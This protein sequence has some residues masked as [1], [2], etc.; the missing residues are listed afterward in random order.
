MREQLRRTVVALALALPAGSSAQEPVTLPA[1]AR[2]RLLTPPVVSPPNAPTSQCGMRVVLVD[3]SLDPAFVKP[4][5]EGPVRFEIRKLPVPC[6]PRTVTPGLPGLVAPP[7]APGT[8][9]APNL[10]APPPAPA[11]PIPPGR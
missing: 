5:P 4:V 1:Q 10:P 7:I 11:V 8:P 3:P 9:E 2:P 6:A